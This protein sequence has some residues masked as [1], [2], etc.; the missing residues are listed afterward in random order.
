MRILII[1]NQYQHIGGEDFVMGQEMEALRKNHEVDLYTVRNQKGWKGYLQYF[2]YPINWSE[3][4]KIKQRMEE[5]KPDIIHIH[6]L[7]YALGPLFILHI[8]KMKIPIVMTLHNFR[9]ICPSATLYFE[10]NIFVNSIKE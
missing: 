7:H 4:K 8:K 9:L 6:N 10:G 2:L 1:H 3:V 5:F